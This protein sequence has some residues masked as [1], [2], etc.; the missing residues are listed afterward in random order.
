M[1][2]KICPIPSCASSSYM[3]FDITNR[4]TPQSSPARPWLP[5]R[6]HYPQTL[7]ALPCCPA[8]SKNIKNNPFLK[9]LVL[10]VSSIHILEGDVALKRW[11]YKT[12][13]IPLPSIVRLSVNM[14]RLPCVPCVAGAWKYL[15]R[16]EERLGARITSNCLRAESVPFPENRWEQNNKDAHSP[17]EKS[18]NRR[19]STQPTR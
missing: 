4:Q 7:E 13:G 10:Y 19:N 14:S 5:R 2:F 17:L 11:V 16:G 8:T 15:E 18:N 9:K 6:K 1:Y 3:Y 12:S